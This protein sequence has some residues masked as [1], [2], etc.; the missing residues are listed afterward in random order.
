MN[1]KLKAEF[2]S[3]ISKDEPLFK[4]LSNS[5]YVEVVREGETLNVL[6][7]TLTPQELLHW[8]NSVTS[9]KKDDYELIKALA[10][11]YALDKLKAHQEF[12]EIEK[13]VMV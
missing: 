1:D 2:I 7:E 5:W 6:L 9:G 8:W 12:L 4:R 3:G 10:L 11:L 13:Y